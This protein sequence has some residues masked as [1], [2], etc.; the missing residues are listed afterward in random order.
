VLIGTVRRTYATHKYYG[1]RIILFDS[2]QCVI[3]F[4]ERLCKMQISGNIP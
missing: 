3:L 2:V 4:N 1:N